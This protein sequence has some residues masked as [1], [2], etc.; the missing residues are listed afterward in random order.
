MSGESRE[1]TVPSSSRPINLSRF[2]LQNV[3]LT[4]TIRTE[5]NEH[6][7]YL[8]FIIFSPPRDRWRCGYCSLDILVANSIHIDMIETWP[9]QKASLVPF[10]VCVARWNGKVREDIVTLFLFASQSNEPSKEHHHRLPSASTTNDKNT[11]R[12]AR[13]NRRANTKTTSH[14]VK[15]RPASAVEAGTL[16]NYSTDH[17]WMIEQKPSN[18]TF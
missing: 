9:C 6:G 1:S 2:D 16:D 5:P 15:D 4:S 12:K 3:Q 10:F 17:S 18:G 8:L 14:A 7:P 13:Q 11:Q